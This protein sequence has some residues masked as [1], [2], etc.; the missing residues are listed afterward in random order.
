MDILSSPHF[1]DNREAVKVVTELPNPAGPSF[2][3]LAG[4]GFSRIS[5]LMFAVMKGEE[6]IEQATDMDAEKLQADQD[7]W[8]QFPGRKASCVLVN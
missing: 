5:A 3:T 6:A 4:K 2:V 1:Y 8:L 7:L